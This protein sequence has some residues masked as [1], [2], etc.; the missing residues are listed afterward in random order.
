MIFVYI[1]LK[2][3]LKRQFLILFI[4]INKRCKFKIK[5]SIT[6]YLKL[7]QNANH[8]LKIPNVGI[9]NPP[10]IR[11]T[12]VRSLMNE[13]DFCNPTKALTQNNK[14]FFQK[15]SSKNDTSQNGF[16]NK[17]SYVLS[18]LL[19]AGYVVHKMRKPAKL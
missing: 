19:L 13:W 3:F 14:D 8:N 9:I 6:R 15:Q 2:K 17:L 1:L 7:T 5:Q 16:I 4:F 10:N 11:K 12:S 18:T